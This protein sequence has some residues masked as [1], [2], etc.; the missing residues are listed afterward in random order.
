MITRPARRPRHRTL[1]CMFGVFLLLVSLG[2]AFRISDALFS[3]SH[4]PLEQIVDSVLTMVSLIL[5]LAG[6][7]FALLSPLAMI[8]DFI[9]K[10]RQLGQRS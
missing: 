5:F 7:V 10:K 2:I 3:K 4:R 6:P 9:M 1:A 8:R